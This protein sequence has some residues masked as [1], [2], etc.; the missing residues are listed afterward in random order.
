MILILFFVKGYDMIVIYFVL[1]IVFGVGFYGI[2]LV[3][4]FVCNGYKIYF[5]GY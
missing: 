2:V 5:W 1:V 4:V 3:I